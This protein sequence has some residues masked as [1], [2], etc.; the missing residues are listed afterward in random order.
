MS[1]DPYVPSLVR[2]NR[3]RTRC[4]VDGCDGGAREGKPYC[5]AHLDHMPYVK[6]LMRA[7]GRAKECRGPGCGVLVEPKA[8]GRAAEYCSAECKRAR[9][10]A[11]R[12]S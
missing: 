8:R 12:A 3:V 4:E 5:M 6:A 9:E 11:R 10:E 2:A 1:R 7:V